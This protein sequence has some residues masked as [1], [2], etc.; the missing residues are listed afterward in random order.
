MVAN[1][2]LDI[3]I[4]AG[5]FPSNTSIIADISTSFDAANAPAVPPGTATPFKLMETDASAPTT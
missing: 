4:V 1:E 3:V 2:L 5:R